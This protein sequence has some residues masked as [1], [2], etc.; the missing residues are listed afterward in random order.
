MCVYYVLNTPYNRARSN[1]HVVVK[2][3]PLE[4]NQYAITD[5]EENSGTV[6][7]CRRRREHI[8]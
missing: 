5:A 6:H 7:R 3:Q 4:N 1:L 2:V 8:S